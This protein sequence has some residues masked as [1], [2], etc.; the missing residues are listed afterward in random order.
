MS[1]LLGGLLVCGSMSVSAQSFLSSSV[2]GDQKY[3]QF[4]SVE[5]IGCEIVFAGVSGLH[6]NTINRYFKRN[7]GIEVVYNGRSG[8]DYALIEA[9]REK[10][11]EIFSAFIE[12]RNACSFSP[13]K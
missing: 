8:E 11:S 7:N 10:V 2:R 12:R 13:F 5:F 6:I 1:A 3:E 9:N 4:G